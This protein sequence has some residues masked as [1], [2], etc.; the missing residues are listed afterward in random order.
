MRG[1][2]TDP[3]QPVEQQPQLTKIPLQLAALLLLGACGFDTN[4]E[5]GGGYLHAQTDAHNA[6]IIHHRETVVD[7]N[8]TNAL[9]V[10]EY[11]LGLRVKP[12]RFVGYRENEISGDYGYFLLDKNTGSL[13]QGLSL[14]EMEKVFSENGWDFDELVR[15]T[16]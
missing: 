1:A 6:W 9:A 16:L 15:A 7:S 14:A 13:L 11:I 5:L 8:V 2:A 12:E 3:K 4:R 10:S